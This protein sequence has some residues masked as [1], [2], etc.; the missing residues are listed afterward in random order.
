MLYG[1]AGYTGTLIAEEAVR[2]GHRPLLVAGRN[3]EKLRV[4]AK[5]LGLEW[6]TF[7]LEDKSALFEATG[8]VDLMLYAAGPF[9]RTARKAPSFRAGMNSADAEGIHLRFL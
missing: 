4:L 5:R 3:A 8:S 7:S 6:E 9:T 1:A 2:R